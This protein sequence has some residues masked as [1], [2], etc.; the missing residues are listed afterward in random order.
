MFN[1]NFFKELAYDECFVKEV[2][3]FKVDEHQ[4]ILKIKML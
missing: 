4:L 2:D 1:R 3:S